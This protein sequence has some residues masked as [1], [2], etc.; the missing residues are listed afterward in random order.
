MTG[1]RGVLS[2][3]VEDRTLTR[4]VSTRS[5]A[6]SG[7]SCSGESARVATGTEP[8]LRDGYEVV[9]LPLPADVLPSCMAVDRTGRSFV[10]SMDG[11]VL[12]VV[13]TD[14]D[15]VLDTY[16][17]WAGTLAPLAARS[18]RRGRCAARRHPRRPA[19]PRRPRRRRLG[20]VVDDAQ[21]R[22]GRD[23]RPP[24]LDDRH[25]PLAGRRLGR[26]PGDRRRPDRDV[27]GRHYL[28]GKAVLV[29]P[30]GGPASWPTASA[31]RPAGRPRPDG[32]VFFTDNQGQQK[33]TCEID[34][35]SPA[36]GTATRARPTRRP[37][38]PSAR[39]Y[40]P[41][42]RIPYPWARSVNGLAFAETGGNFGPLEGQLVLCEYNNRFILRASLEDGR[43]RR[44][45]GLLPVPRRPP[46]PDLPGVRPRRHPLRR[47]PP[48]AGLGRRARAGGDLPR[49]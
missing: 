43:R 8:G 25:R 33:T 1:S 9:R 35:S 41:V 20:R 21:R 7:S 26:Q 34:A 22:L 11:D 30:G 42:V 39:R 27:Q 15:G 31:I 4:P 38:R 16:R 23:P 37:V 2:E 12:R 46:R 24:R 45:G 32:A 36:P 28:R 47:Q 48:R 6:S 14:G 3:Q 13:D 19:S 49:P 10:G 18:D 40:H 17:R 29:E 5:G 44:A